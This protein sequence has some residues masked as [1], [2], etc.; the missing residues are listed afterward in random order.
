MSTAGPAAA[1]ADTEARLRVWPNPSFGP[2]WLLLVPAGTAEGGLDVLGADG[3]SAGVPVPA[4]DG[5]YLWSGR[6]PGGRSLPSGIYW[7]R[8][9]RAGTR[10]LV[11]P[12]IL[13]R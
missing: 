1:P 2:T 10:P 3:R 11:A 6:D 13:V 12:L 4:G 7:A 5:L 8:A 9:R